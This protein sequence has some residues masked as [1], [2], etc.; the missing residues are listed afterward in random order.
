MYKVLLILL[1][2]PLCCVGQSVQYGTIVG[3][4]FDNRTNLPLTDANIVLEGDK[5]GTISDKNGK[6][7]LN[8]I[9]EGNYTLTVSY[10]GYQSYR[11]NIQV[12][13]G[14][15][16][17]L[18]I[19]LFETQFTA[20]E[21]NVNANRKINI[22][23]QSNRIN[24]ISDST[25]ASAPIHSI[26]ELIDYMPGINLNNTF[27]IYSS[28]TIVTLHGLPSNNQSR[29]LVLLDGVPLNKSDEGSVNWNMINKNNIQSVKI[30]K[31]PGPAKYGSGAMGGVIEMISKKPDKHIQGDVQT[32]YGTYNTMLANA[33]ISGTTSD[34]AS[35]NSFYWGLNGMGRK[36]DG[37]ITELDI[38]R[39]A[40][41]SILVPTYLKEW[42]ATAKAGYNI[43]NH[44][45]IEGQFN[46]YDD[47][48]GNGVKVFEDMGAY[49]TH[50]TFS[51]MINYSGKADLFKWSA[52][53]F[54]LFE[55]Y[56]RQYEYMKE[57]EYQLYGADSKRRDIGYNVD[58]TANKFLQSEITI[59]FNYKLGSVNGKDTYYTSTDIIS[60]AGN[61]QTVAVYLQDEMKFLKDKLNINVGL[62]YDAAHFYNGLFTIE[63][64][65]YSIE[66]YENFE[67]TSVPS[68]NWNAFCPRF[69]AQYLFSD[70]DRIYFSLAKGF[71]AP[72]LDDMTRTGKKKGGFSI[73]NPN[74]KPELITTY[75][76]GGDKKMVDKLTTSCSIYYSIG[77]DFMYLVSN[78]DS[79]NMGY[80]LAPVMTM[81]NI[82]QVKIYGAE[83][84]LK[85]N[86]KEQLSLFAN[87]AYAHAQITKNNINNTKVDSNLTGK[88][89]TDVPTNK[90]SAG[91]TWRNKI[92]NTTV[93]FK[94]I[95]KTWI[96]DLNIVDID[97]LNKDKYPEYTTFNIRLE[98]K[99]IKGMTVGV[100]IENIFDKIYVTSDAQ[101]C[102]GRLITGSLQYVF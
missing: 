102:P 52:N 82:N 84:E 22:Y 45:T 13:K 14:Q 58:F 56:I 49:S 7:T 65:S 39:T 24:V 10:M 6:F 20:N 51:E 33:D 38:Y 91:I 35:S 93:L 53:F 80:K 72:I 95:G 5:T 25:I 16:V 17:S 81:K 89:L 59:G 18:T 28:K 76:I 100:S 21:I 36:S 87:Y 98:R 15:T 50:R 88:Y 79:V 63:Y 44:H 43:H 4:I 12:K 64:P 2:F 99:I 97:Y 19:K 54:N 55:N 42:N 77:K 23:E 62:R 73:A 8:H 61:M 11:K 83:V 70:N 3:I 9:A 31:G 75:E 71:R 60:N 69:S 78:G 66:F 85:Y 47:I 67:N 74:L 37:Y 57:G 46:Y 48:R 41:D 27:G 32:E 94:F 90:V 86:P 92:V 101:T 96:N 40:A 29:T 30:I 26:P 1:L 68:K 34:S